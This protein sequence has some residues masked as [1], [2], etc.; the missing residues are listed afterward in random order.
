MRVQEA[1]RDRSASGFTRI[2]LAAVLTLVTVLC[3]LLNPALGS[4][5]LNSQRIRCST[6]FKTLIR[7]W[8][9]YSSEN[10]DRL[11][12][13]FHGGDAM[14]GAVAQDPAKAPWTVGWLDWATSSD[15]TN[16]LLLTADRY[17]RL[18]PYLGHSAEAFHCPSDLYVSGPQRQ[19]GWTHRA[20]SVSGNIG[21][22]DGNAES[23]PF[24][25]T[26]YKHIKKQ[27]DFLY[28][29]PAQTWVYL[30]EHPDS[31]NDP[32]FF[33]PN[34]TYWTDQPASFHNGATSLAFADG[35]VEAH[36]WQA[37]LAR[38]GSQRT[39]FLVYQGVVA[40]SGDPDIGWI[41]FRGGRLSDQSD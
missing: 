13:S 14:R 25:G 12:M 11:V 19:R 8:Q 10:Q 36:K 31:I 16:T 32:A 40:K 18:A 24:L 41:A 7:A 2:E 6:N 30:E 28:P 21:I 38:A 3:G 29:P 34:P 22:G 1:A 23:G 33:N 27:S 20:R 26:I 5:Q 15:N 17:T 39:R 9:L 4:T 37:S 35:H